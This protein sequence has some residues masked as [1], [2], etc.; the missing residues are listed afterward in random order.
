MPEIETIVNTSAPAN[1]RVGYPGLGDEIRAMR[2]KTGRS[3]E[4]IAA[5]LGFSWMTVHRWE[6]GMRTVDHGVLI[7]FFKLCGGTLNDFEAREYTHCGVIWRETGEFKEVGPEDAFLNQGC[8]VP[9]MPGFGQPIGDRIILKA[10]G[11]VGE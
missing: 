6:R 10:V 2:H 7:R 8:A 3:Q 4:S 1:Q 9:Q 5:E 11:I